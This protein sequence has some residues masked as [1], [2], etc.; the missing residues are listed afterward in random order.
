[1]DI[2]IFI[3]V[4]VE[5]LFVSPAGLDKHKQSFNVNRNLST[6][7]QLTLTHVITMTS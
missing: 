5:E 7:G 2:Q 1:M 3:C 6:V 4:H